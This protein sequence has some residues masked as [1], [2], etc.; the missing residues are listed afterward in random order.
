MTYLISGNKVDCCGCCACVNVCNHDAI[1]MVADEEGFL[2]PSRNEKCIKCG[3]CENVCPYSQTRED[4]INCSED[5]ENKSY[6]KVYAAYSEKDRKDS[7]SGGI[8]YVISKLVLK[9]GGVVLGASFDSNLKLA[10]WQ[11]KIC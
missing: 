2:Y 5:T 7:S 11:L 9:N 8:F 6:P 4:E 10:M 3:L 1:K